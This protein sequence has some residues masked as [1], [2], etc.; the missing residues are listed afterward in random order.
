VKPIDYDAL[1][2]DPN[3]GQHPAPEPGAS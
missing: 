3:D 2:V 1:I